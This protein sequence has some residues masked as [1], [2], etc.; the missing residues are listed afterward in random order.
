MQT[1]L[2]HANLSDLMSMLTDQG[3]R[4]LDVVATSRSMRMEHTKLRLYGTE[5]EL[6]DDG[7]IP[8]EGVYTPTSVFDDGVSSKLDIPR[9]Y[10]R[11]LRE[12]RPDIYDATVNMWLHGS[13]D[14]APDARKFM[15][16][17]FRGEGEDGI[18]R[19][20]MSSRYG[21][22][23]NFDILS[24]VLD[25]VRA[26]GVRVEIPTGGC[27][28]TDRRMYVRITAPQVRAYAPDLFKGYRSPF[29]GPNSGRWLPPSMFD[30]VGDGGTGLVFAG[31]AVR[32]SEVG[33]SRFT[34]APV[35][36]LQTCGNGMTITGDA[37][38]AQHVGVDQDEGVVKW[39]ADTERKQL[40]LV[41]A[42]ARDAVATF[43]DSDYITA[44]LD[45]IRE[46][47]ST[48][49]KDVPT[50]IETLGKKMNY[51]DAERASILEHFI[52]GGQ[53]TAGGL[54]NAITS[55]AQVVTD[56]DEANRLEESALEAL[57][58]VGR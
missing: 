16:R 25:G 39:T 19:A 30:D 12:N 15:L 57:A 49:I 43:L 14:Y 46:Q 9:A 33:F 3:A 35:A 7:V 54:L 17:L 53:Q 32:N 31:L 50:T 24:A 20:M 37:I 6:T 8:T 42:K 29:E 4:Q 26:A 58:F 51:S 11:R 18:A 55:T 45:E 5:A 23:D 2:R 10:L 56:A 21:I 52:A 36:I 41:K 27:D 47:A 22:I 38:K 44:K 28:L 13:T 34:I 48:K 40:E 1:T